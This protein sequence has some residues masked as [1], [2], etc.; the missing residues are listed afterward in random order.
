MAHTAGQ[1]KL[2]TA[3][4]YLPSLSSAGSGWKAGKA[5]TEGFETFFSSQIKPLGIGRRKS[6]YVQ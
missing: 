4:S 3:P 1:V 6:P 2:L 5:I